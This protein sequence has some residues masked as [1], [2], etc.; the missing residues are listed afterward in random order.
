MSTSFTVRWDE[1]T[2]RDFRNEKDAFKFAKR[3]CKAGFKEILLSAWDG[4]HD[5]PD[6][7]MIWYAL[8]T[9]NGEFTI[10]QD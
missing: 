10:Y 5:D 1:D 2:Y 9:E 4:A 6:C 3:K 8:F 7:G